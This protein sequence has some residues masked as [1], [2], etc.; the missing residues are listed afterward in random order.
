MRNAA[1]GV[2]GAEPTAI[3]R[4]RAGVRG[5]TNIEVFFDLVYAFAVTQLS[6]YLLNHATLEGALQTAVLLTMVWWV[7]LLTTGV[8]NWLNPNHV[9]VRLLLISLMLVSIVLSASLPDAFGDRGLAVGGAYAVL[10]IGR[11]SFTVLA[12]R[13]DRLQRNVE[14]VLSWS[15]VGGAFAVAGGVVHGH[16]RELLWVCAVGIEILGGMVGNYTPGLG[17]STTREWDIEGSHIAERCQS[18][19]MIALGE[20]IVVIGAGLAGKSAVAAAEVTALVIA[21]AGAVAIWWIYFA[22]GAVEATRVLATSPDPGRLGRDAYAYIHPVMIG[23]IIAVAAGDSGVLASPLSIA[24][25]ATTAML[26]GGTMLFLAGH[27]LFKW[28]LWHVAS[29][30]RVV[31]IAVLAGLLVVGPHIPGLA[32]E[33]C[34]A[35]ILILVAATDH[36]L[37]HRSLTPTPATP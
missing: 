37:Y 8:T 35:G 27:A 12:L 33:A 14:R 10:Q 25:V 4:V 31:A 29:W 32:V 17:R 2:S 1:D 16:L 19:V 7:W 22:R 30:T 11:G 18:F 15:I 20:S 36:Y 23:G 9:A 3:R 28:T 24:S 26:L 5:E 34:A 6:H 21:F 13:G